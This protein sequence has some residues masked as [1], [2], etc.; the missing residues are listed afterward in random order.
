MSL[1][2]SLKTVA[3]AASVCAALYGCGTVS[4]DDTTGSTP[5]TLQ[6]TVK[7]SS[8][9]AVEDPWA[10]SLIALATTQA[11][12]NFEQMADAMA[13]SDMSTVRASTPASA[14]ALL[15]QVLTKYP[16]H[17]GAQFAKATVTIADIV[18]SSELDTLVQLMNGFSDE[19]EDEDV[20]TDQSAT[21]TDAAALFR[22]KAEDVPATLFVS[23]ASLN[24]ADPV[25]ITRIQNAVEKAVLPIL[26]TTIAY[27]QNAMAYDSFAFR[28]V[29]DGRTYE[30]DK[31]EVGPAL[32]ALKLAKAYVVFFVAREIEVSKDGTY[33]WVKSL[34]GLTLED[35]DS[36][37]AEQTA[38]LDHMTA[39][40]NTN[41]LFSTIKADWKTKYAGIPALLESAITD[42]QNGLNYGIKESAT[43]L[44]TQINDIYIVGTDV[45]ADVSPADLKEAVDDLERVKKY[46]Q[47]PVT[48]TYNYGS[49]SLTFNATK[50]FSIVDGYQDLLPYHVI[51]PYASWNDSVGADTLFSYENDDGSIY[52]ATEKV[53]RGP[54]YFTDASGKATFG[55][56]IETELNALIDAQGLASLADKIIFPDPTF[57]GV[58]PGMTNA[59]LWTTV[60]SLKTVES[61]SQHCETFYYDEGNASS[62]YEHCYREMPSN[63]SDLDLLTY[64]LD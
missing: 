24:A 42:A 23:S 54:F 58:F 36:L 9:N 15:Q 41:S 40:F 6:T 49:N 14:K 39:L 29:R 33:D 17:C 5:N 19:G 64:Y 46:L 37:T 47:G 25:T 8:C 32:A 57:G 3:C 4:D 55:A 35:V 56:D 43:G 2:I 7:V 30:I 22:L 50:F 16:G 61:R 28:F 31:G 44:Q 60:A 21:S 18:N 59:K 38:A 1:P 27:L 10:D 20:A 26:D 34:E 52:T 62:S 12:T 53:K 45:N 63:P 11:Q 51:N 13:K 48:V